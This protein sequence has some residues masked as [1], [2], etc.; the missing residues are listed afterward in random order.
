MELGH[1]LGHVKSGGTLQ[2]DQAHALVGNLLDREFSSWEL[3]DFLIALAARGETPAEIAGAAD[4]LRERMR[5]FEHDAPNAIDTCGTGGDGL[6]SFNVSTAAAIVAAAA[7][8]YV[9]KH[10]NRSQSS[11][12]GSADLLEAAG[13]PLELDEA[14]A[15]ACLESAHITFLFAPAAHPLLARV[16]PVRKA[17][18]IRTLFNFLGPLCNPGRVRRQLIGVPE[19][20]CVAPM[21]DALREL[22]HERAYVVHGE[23]G[24]DELVPGASNAVSAVGAVPPWTDT[25]SAAFRTASHEDLRGGDAKANLGTLARLLEGARSPVRDAV[26]LNAGAAL[27]VAGV[28]STPDEGVARADEALASRAARVTFDRWIAAAR[29]RA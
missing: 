11:R 6:R 25:T 29:R 15:R 21:A 1:A 2:R 5:V 20:R 16:A 9:V 28:A 23:G 22:G 27:V 8:A 19:A 12:C 3:V 14:R 10:G 18:G 7:G 13:I 4:A 17:L 24:A 26:V